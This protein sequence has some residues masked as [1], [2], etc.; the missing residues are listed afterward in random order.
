VQWDLFDVS[1]YGI[2]MEAEQLGF[3]PC[4]KYWAEGVEA[5]EED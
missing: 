3:C 1:G 5:M 2:F 4:S